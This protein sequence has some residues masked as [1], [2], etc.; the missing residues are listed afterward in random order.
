MVGQPQTKRLAATVTTVADLV[1]LP[2]WIEHSLKPINRLSTGKNTFI[3]NFLTQLIIS[4]LRH[5]LFPLLA[6]LLEKC[7]EATRGEQDTRVVLSGLENDVRAFIQHGK[8]GNKK[9][10][11]DDPEVDGLVG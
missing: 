7:E 11:T 5:P 2:V 8:D 10:M 1:R 9:L 4:V 3:K 6:L